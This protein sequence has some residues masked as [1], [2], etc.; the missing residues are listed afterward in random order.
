MV[1]ELLLLIIHTKKGGR[2][3]YSKIFIVVITI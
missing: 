1:L 2:R 3:I